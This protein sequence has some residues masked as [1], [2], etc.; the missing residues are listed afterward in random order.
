MQ[1]GTSKAWVLWSCGSKTTPI[2]Y[3]RDVWFFDPAPES[4][5]NTVV[6]FDDDARVQAVIQWPRSINRFWITP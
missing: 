3:N 4:H 1:I 6:V 2:D 5:D